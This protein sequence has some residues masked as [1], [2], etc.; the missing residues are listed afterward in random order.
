MAT[1]TKTRAKTTR[2]HAKAKAP[3]RTAERK[4]KTAARKKPLTT[5]QLTTQIMKHGGKRLAIQPAAEDAKGYAVRFTRDG[6]GRKTF[7]TEASTLL[8]AM[9]ELHRE[10]TETL[11]GGGK[12]T[13][14]KRR[15][16][17]AVA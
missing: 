4:P 16:K 3:A 2:A 9:R 5:D 13:Q 10:V 11:S 12:Q 8:A 15:R 14:G 6:E 7:E 1:A 17:Q